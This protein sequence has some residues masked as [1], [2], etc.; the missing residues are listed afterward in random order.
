MDISKAIQFAKFAQ[1][2]KISN[3]CG[4]RRDIQRK[5]GR[6]KRISPL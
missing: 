5:A 3:F 1:K 2:K 6:N 4:S